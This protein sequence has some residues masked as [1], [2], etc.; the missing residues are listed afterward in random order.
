MS[1]RL[2]TFAERSFDIVKF[3]IFAIEPI[4]KPKMMKLW[5]PGI[6]G[7]TVLTVFYCSLKSFFFRVLILKKSFTH[8]VFPSGR[9]LIFVISLIERFL[10]IFD[11][12]YIFVF[13]RWPDLMCI[14]R[15]WSHHRHQW[16]VQ[17][18]KVFFH[19]EF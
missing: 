3:R 18:H 1:T 12:L 6:A 8:Y 10:D 5:M 19:L 11:C 17:K 4:V 15:M 14:V 2:S 9:C 16:P 13:I 7:C